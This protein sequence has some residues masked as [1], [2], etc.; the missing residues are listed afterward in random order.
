MAEKNTK[1]AID[2]GLSF[3][4]DKLSTSYQIGNK[5]DNVYDHCL[6]M[7]GCGK[8]PAGMRL[9]SIRDAEK[10]WGVNRVAIQQA[11]KKLA[12]QGILISK[13]RSGYYVTS[14]ENIH[15]ISNYRVELE[16][17]YQEF[18]ETILKTTNLAPL[19][20]FRYLAKLAQIN[21]KE[22]PQCAFVECTRIQAEAHAKEIFDRLKV[23]VMPM[24]VTEI[25]GR[26][27]RIPTHVNT[28]LTTH[29]HS[30][31][32]MP[33]RKSGSLE[34]IVIPIEVSPQLDEMVKHSRNV[35]ILL[36]EEQQTAK[37]V[38]DDAGKI[39]GCP[40]LEIKL[41][42]K[43][44]ATLV[45]MLESTDLP[46]TYILVSPRE[47]NSIDQKWREHPNVQLVPFRIRDE[48]WDLIADV[49]G[50]PLG[51]LG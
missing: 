21:D 2:S 9:P 5:Q 26:R 42:N 36:E 16:N 43:L 29:F 38:A 35:I 4:N 32:L 18:S 50:M 27:N 11:Y 1:S 20:V 22:T 48:A 30:A 12:L 37:T 13:S 49:V 28:L 8:W 24:T 6:M 25:A 44:H 14:Q 10:I 46:E 51:V 41:T 34:V 47:W 7:I 33:L 31:E 3:E 15:R 19:P 39:L 23:S 40:P 17:L 45:D